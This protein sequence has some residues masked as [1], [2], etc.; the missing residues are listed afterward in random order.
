MQGTHAVS[1]VGI[2]IDKPSRNQQDPV[3][4]NARAR[5]SVQLLDMAMQLSCEARCRSTWREGKQHKMNRLRLAFLPGTHTHAEIPPNVTSTAVSAGA[6]IM[7]PF[8][9]MHLHKL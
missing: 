5:T 8:H 3:T 2:D 6:K 7:R 9:H 4:M 1:K